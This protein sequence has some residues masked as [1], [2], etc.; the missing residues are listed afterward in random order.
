MILSVAGVHFKYNS[1]PVL[2][3]I[4]FELPRGKTL[5]LLGVN[6]AGKSTLLRCLNGILKVK[7]GS[8]IIDG[9][10]A[11]SMGSNE[12]AKHFAYVPQNH[13]DAPLSVFDMVLLGRKPHMTWG[14]SEQD[15]KRV[16]QILDLMGLRN[17]A[18]RQTNRLSGGEIQKVI[19]ARALV[20]EPKVLLLDEPT[21]NLDLRNQLQVMDLMKHAVAKQGIS[22]VVSVHDINLAFRYADYFLM[23]KNGTVYTLSSKQDITPEMIRDVYGVDVILEKVQDYKIVIPV[24]TLDEY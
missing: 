7:T 9:K 23:L 1:R 12:V 2:K 13:T 21:S 22:A 10:D 24:G 15:L 5:A 16:E 6:G 14:P 8:V 3:D 11:L 20:Q 17:L 4:S 19:M 18:M